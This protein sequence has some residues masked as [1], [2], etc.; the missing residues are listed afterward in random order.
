MGQFGTAARMAVIFSSDLADLEA[1]VTAYEHVLAATYILTR[2]L[3]SV[4][5]W[6]IETIGLSLINSL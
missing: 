1:L 5:H 2:V 4:R 6:V 3:G